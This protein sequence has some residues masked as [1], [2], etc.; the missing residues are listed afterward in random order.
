M[1]LVAALLIFLVGVFASFIGGML[2]G[3][4]S[5]ISIPALTFLGLP[6]SIAVATNRFG[7]VGGA[8][9]SIFKFAKA[10]QILLKYVLPLTIISVIGSVIGAKILIE[11]NE[12]LLSKVMGILILIILP[13]TFLKRELGLKRKIVSKYYKI[14]GFIIYFGVAIY[15]GFFGAGAGIIAV[16]LLIFTF[17]LTYIEANATEK[18]PWFLNV[19][20]STI[21]FAVYGLINYVYGLFILAGMIVGG[22]LGAHVAIKKGN[23]FVKTLFSIIVI[24]SALKLIFF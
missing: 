20:V 15:D 17:G 10:K 8:A 18:I 24:V 7:C 14:F 11:F 19:V 9:S 22:Y 1:D 3:G 2:G 13:F 12:D 16:F 6:P 5:L 4:G 23:Y 21:I